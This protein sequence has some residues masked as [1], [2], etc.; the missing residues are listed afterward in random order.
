M[1]FGTREA[2]RS[3]TNTNTNTNV[4]GDYPA[5]AFAVFAEA[6]RMAVS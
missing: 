2:L 3:N 5:R 4:N 1:V 6:L